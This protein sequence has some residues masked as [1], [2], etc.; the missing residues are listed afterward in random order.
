[1]KNKKE[2]GE[3]GTG[4]DASTLPHHELQ[5]VQGHACVK[6]SALKSP[7]IAIS[8]G[9]HEAPESMNLHGKANVALAMLC[10]DKE[11]WDSRESVARQRYTSGRE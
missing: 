11:D 2:M 7:D 10:N 9:L 6:Q 1:M 8:L 4:S 5:L 3:D